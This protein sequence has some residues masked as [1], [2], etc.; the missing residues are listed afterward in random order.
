MIHRLL[1][2][3]DFSV[4]STNDPCSPSQIR[5]ETVRARQCL[6]SGDAERPIFNV[7]SICY[8]LRSSICCSLYLIQRI[9]ATHP[10]SILA[11]GLAM[12]NGGPNSIFIKAR[13]Y[14][15]SAPHLGNICIRKIEIG[16][17]VNYAPR[18]MKIAPTHPA[19]LWTCQQSGAYGPAECPV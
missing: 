5:L 15:R 7:P 14:W 16:G 4:G 19:C 17:V 1:Q 9:P 3:L 13:I 18:S 2:E 10:S 11:G 8:S 6:H 12:E